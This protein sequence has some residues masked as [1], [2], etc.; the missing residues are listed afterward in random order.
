M[1]KTSGDVTR[2]AVERALPIIAKAKAQL[3]TIV[4]TGPNQVAMTE[5]D[6]KEAAINDPSMLK[7]AQ[8]PD[9][10]DNQLLES[11]LLQG[12]IGA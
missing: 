6:L 2:M 7:Y 12:Q 4:Y 10:V 3:S 1:S 9:S 11:M 8:S 5:R